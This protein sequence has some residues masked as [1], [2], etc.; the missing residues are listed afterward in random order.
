M[1]TNNQTVALESQP[2]NIIQQLLQKY[3]GINFGTPSSSVVQNAISP[4]A[5]ASDLLSPATV[6]T[7]TT[8][9]APDTNLL[10]GETTGEATT[11]AA[12]ATDAATGSG[13]FADY[14]GGWGNVIKGI[15]ALGNLYTG[16]QNIGIA[17]DYLDLAQNQYNTNK[18]LMQANLDNS[19]Q[20]Y[21][22]SLTDRLTS[23]AYAETGDSSAYNDT[24]NERKLSSANLS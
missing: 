17:K 23:R 5:T 12:N 3:L 9:L 19:V 2:T 14:F 22:N 13:S 15:T 24:I 11:Q 18:A 16:I 21:N 4:T 7:S 20:T 8:T 10:T 1:T 6:S